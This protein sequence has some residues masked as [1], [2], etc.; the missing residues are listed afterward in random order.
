VEELPSCTCKKLVKQRKQSLLGW[1]S[2]CRTK[3]PTILLTLPIH[4][5]RTSKGL[6]NG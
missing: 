1:V 3:N 2:H 5:V 6:T 4:H